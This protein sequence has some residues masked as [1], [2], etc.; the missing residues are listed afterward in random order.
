VGDGDCARSS[1][2][3]HRPPPSPEIQRRRLKSCAV[4]KHNA[5]FGHF[6]AEERRVRKACAMPIQPLSGAVPRIR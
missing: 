5:T 3:A 4:P 1:P 2:I 6:E